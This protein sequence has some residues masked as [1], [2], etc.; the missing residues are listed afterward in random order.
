VV[1]DSQVLGKRRSLVRTHTHA[2]VAVE[3]AFRQAAIGERPLECLGVMTESVDVGCLGIVAQSYADNY[4][5]A[6]RHER[7]SYLTDRTTA[8]P[9]ALNIGIDVVVAS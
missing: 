8:K 3:L 6:I 1:L 7:R 5:G 4:R 2:G 9:T